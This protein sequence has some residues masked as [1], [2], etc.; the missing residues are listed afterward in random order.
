MI[1]DALV[2]VQFDALPRCG[3]LHARELQFDD[4]PDFRP[5]QR[6]E[7]DDFVD[8][9]DEFRPEMSAKHL[10]EVGLLPGLV[11]LF[12]PALLEVALDDV[13]PEVRRGDD[14]G[15]AEIHHAPLAVGQPA[16][17]EDLQQDVVDIRV[18]LLDLV[19]QDHRI[20]PTPHALGQL[21]AFVITD[22]ARRCTDQTRDG[23]AF[24]IF[25]HVDADHRILVAIDGFGQRLGQFGLA[26]AGR[27]EEQEG[28][29]RARAL[30][31]P[32]ARQTHGVGHGADRLFLADDALMQPV[33]ELQKLVLLLGRQF[34]DRNAGDLGDDLGDMIG[35]D[36]GR[37]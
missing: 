9:V 10:H 1:D 18:R 6:M 3:P 35:A 7:D 27:A 33:F 31:Q 24:A 19:E 29:R 25:R 34:R 21:A 13:G 14:D 30:A 36:F 26:D 11:E 22:I 15:I 17:I 20:G 28:C 8:P 32:G 12:G 23:V 2:A 16:V 5:V 37:G 4:L